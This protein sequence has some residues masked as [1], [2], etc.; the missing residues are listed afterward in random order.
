MNIS[1]SDH[2]QTLAKKQAIAAGF[3][4][5]AEY[6]ETMIERAE[7][8]AED[9]MEIIAAVREGLDD[10]A[11]GRVRPIRT[12]LADLARKYN[13]PPTPEN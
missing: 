9:E 13:L 10:V 11:A 3:T 7:T 4:N 8:Q 6:L 2:H 12:A 1:I 5:I